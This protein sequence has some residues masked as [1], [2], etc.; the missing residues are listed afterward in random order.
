[1]VA[2]Q[3]TATQLFTVMSISLDSNIDS[4][5]ESILSEL[6]KNDYAACRDTNYDI[7]SLISDAKNEY[8]EKVCQ[9]VERLFQFDEET[10]NRQKEYISKRV[11]DFGTISQ[12]ASNGPSLEL[13]LSSW[14]WAKEGEEIDKSYLERITLKENSLV[15]DAAKES[16]NTAISKMPIRE[17]VVEEV[18][19]TIPNSGGFK[20]QVADDT[21]IV[22]DAS[23]APFYEEVQSPASEE[24][25][26][27]LSIAREP[28]KS[29]TPYVLLGLVI[30]AL[31]ALNV[32]QYYQHQMEG[33]QS[34]PS[35]HQSDS[36]VAEYKQKANWFDK[37]FDESSNH[38]LGWSSNSFHASEGFIVLNK[39]D[40]ARNIQLTAD[41]DD[42]VQV[43]L[44][45]NGVS[46]EVDFTEDSWDG[47]TTTI[48]VTPTDMAGV[49]IA[50][51][52]S[53]IGNESFRVVIFVK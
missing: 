36:K 53:S 18:I 6:E 23:M 52:T 7:D 46:A 47:S 31:I 20:K 32:F 33:Y 30:L 44:D 41:Y 29:K 48:S 14:F 38:K 15:E 51:F 19:S 40:S 16:I 25:A 8:R 13:L 37:I 42:S 22:N 1:M 10:A 3:N 12:S 35:T 39:A 27:E 24:K 45:V 2:Q 4:L 9:D 49:T 28:K 21:S 5:K 11:T 34:E 26:Q 50:T 43:S 17:D